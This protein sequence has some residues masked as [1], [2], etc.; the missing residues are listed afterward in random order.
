[1]KILSRTR[2]RNRRGVAFIEFSLIL[3]VL[4]PLMLGTAGVGLNMLRSLSTIQVA[5]D[6]GHMFAR[7]AD[8]SQ[9]GNQTI[10]ANLGADIGLTT[11]AA[12][13]KAV[14]V[15][16]TVIYIDK[17][18]CAADGKVDANGNPKNCTNYG[19]WAFAKRLIIGDKTM[20]TSNY[21]SPIQGPQDPVTIDGTGKISVHDQVSN[22][23]DVAYFNMI[24]PY[25]V[26][27]GKVSG[28]PSGQVIYIAEAASH[29]IKIPPFVPNSIMYSYNM[30]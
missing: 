15:L 22:P 25:Q 9:P 16:S 30:F 17:A 27:Q 28:L 18:M 23:N 7:G 3:L 2:A 24:T 13:S 26:V 4:V 20:R 29:G 8:F 14:V 12:T 1:M 6:A 10:I 11:D 21:G 5:R 19:S